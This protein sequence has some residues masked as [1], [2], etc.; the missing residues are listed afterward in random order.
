MAPAMGL[1]SSSPYSISR[2]PSTGAIR[3]TTIAAAEIRDATRSTVATARAIGDDPN[4][5]AAPAAPPAPLPDAT[6]GDASAMCWSTDPSA[7]PS[8]VAC[9]VPSGVL[10]SPQ[11]RDAQHARTHTR[12]HASD[13]Q[14]PN[15]AMK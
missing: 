10:L 2:S 6:L 15:P 8:A 9:R 5:T 3:D 12:A 4:S 7:V 1:P 14:I 11:D 13:G